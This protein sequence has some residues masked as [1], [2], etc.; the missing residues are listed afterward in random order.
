ME[1]A[2]E[3][4]QRITGIDNKNRKKQCPVKGYIE[5]KRL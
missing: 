2:Y 4:I 3:E 5:A 1:T